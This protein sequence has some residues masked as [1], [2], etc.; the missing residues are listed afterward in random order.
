ML[1]ILITLALGILILHYP[2]LIP[3]TLADDQ[4][5]GTAV[6]SPEPVLEAPQPIHTTSRFETKLV[7]VKIKIPRQI[8]KKDDPDLEIDNDTIAQ[9]GKDGLRTETYTVLYYEGQEYSRELTTVAIDP[10]QDQIVN[11]GT[12]IVWRTIDTADGQITYWRKLHVWATQ[13]DSHCLGCDNTTAIGMQQ[14]KGVVAVDP[15]VIK[16]RSKLYIPGYGQ[17]V[18]G[19]VGGAIQGNM[20][21]VGFP[22]AHTSGWYSHYVDVYLE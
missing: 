5:L 2:N 6:T 10:P 4:V 16:L 9:E 20:I 14:G 21:D 1:K 7:D 11:H 18:A 8:V 13:Y 17:A 22:D 15:S 19:D 3:Q 12:K